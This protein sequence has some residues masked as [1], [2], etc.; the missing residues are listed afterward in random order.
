M[1]TPQINSSYLNTRADKKVINK[2]YLIETT[3]FILTCF[4]TVL[5]LRMHFSIGGLNPIYEMQTLNKMLSG[6]FPLTC[7]TSW[8]VEQIWTISWPQDEYTE[9]GQAVKLIT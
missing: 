5:N 2:L 4:R 1:F 3:G 6:M 8:L 7:M 9:C